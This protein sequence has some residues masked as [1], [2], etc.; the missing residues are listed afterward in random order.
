VGSG[1][2]HNKLPGATVAPGTE[3]FIVHADKSLHASGVKASML[4]GAHINSLGGRSCGVP[5]RAHSPR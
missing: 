2:L 3:V 4:R 5:A 1:N